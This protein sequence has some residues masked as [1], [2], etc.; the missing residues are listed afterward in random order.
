MVRGARCVTVRDGGG[1]GGCYHLDFDSILAG[2]RK[3]GG[4][5]PSDSII[6]ESTYELI[7]ARS[8]FVRV[9]VH[10]NGAW[11]HRGRQYSR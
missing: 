3:F 4:R 2:D 10:L 5:F 1:G 9:P 11:R 8:D 6:V 7:V